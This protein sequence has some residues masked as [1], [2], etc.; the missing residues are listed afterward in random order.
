M[1][2]LKENPNYILNEYLE[3]VLTEEQIQEIRKKSSNNYRVI[4]WEARTIGNDPMNAFY[5]GDDFRSTSSS[6]SSPTRR[7]STT[8]S[9]IYF[10]PEFHF[11]LKK[12]TNTKTR[13]TPSV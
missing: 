7:S 11:A 8:P 9:S 5:F 6:S 10:G 3:N 12:K 4:P 13:K 2:L 1:D